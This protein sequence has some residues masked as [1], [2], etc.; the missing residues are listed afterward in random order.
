M[1]KRWFAVRICV[2]LAV[3]AFVVSSVVITILLEVL[4]GRDTW[5]LWPVYLFISSLVLFYI[6]VPL[7]ALG[8]SVAD[9]ASNR[10]K[11]QEPS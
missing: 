7:L 5:P 3:A 9:W 11:Q 1:K 4:D 6:I 10:W 8:A 2:R